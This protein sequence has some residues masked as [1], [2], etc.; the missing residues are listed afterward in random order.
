MDPRYPEVRD[1]IINNCLHF[2]NDW[3]LDGLKLDFIDQFRQPEKELPDADPGR[4]FDSVP[5]ALDFMLNRLVC[6][7]KSVKPDI[8][9]EFRQMYIGPVMRKYGNMFR[10]GDCAD[11]ILLNRVRTTDV[12]LIA[13]NSSVHSDMI[14][15]HKDEDAEIAA[16]Q[17]LNVIFSVLQISVK[18][19][20]ITDEQKKCLLFGLAL[21]AGIRKFC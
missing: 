11:D 5:R 1:H 17:L 21:Q 13:G 15:W 3:K 20:E 7:L 10:A 8:M 12:R 14:P 2:V 6:V 4:D 16:R 9:I 19:D 18:I